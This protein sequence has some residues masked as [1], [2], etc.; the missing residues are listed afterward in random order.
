MPGENRMNIDNN[1][2]SKEQLLTPEEAAEILRTTVGVLA[3]W[4]STGRV[5]LRF[6]KLGGKVLY[7]LSAIIEYLDEN[8]STQ[9]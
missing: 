1:L 5:N 3:V 7:R 4:R 8:E 9:V 6:I 2:M